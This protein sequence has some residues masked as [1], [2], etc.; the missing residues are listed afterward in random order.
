SDPELSL[1]TVAHSL[2]ISRRYL[3]RLLKTSGT[4]FTAQV[5]E[6]RLRQ[7]FKFL[8][9]SELRISDL[10]LRVG[11]SDISHFNRLFRSR[12]GDT[13]KRIRTHARMGSTRPAF[14]LRYGSL[15]SDSRL[16]GDSRGAPIT[17]YESRA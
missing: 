8:Q 11:F 7:A 9:E 3:Q 5:T 16:H 17:R 6:L 14:S 4:S 10:A 15:N 2:R 13:P 12:F 1:T